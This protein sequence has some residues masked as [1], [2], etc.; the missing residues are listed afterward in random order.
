MTRRSVVLPEPDGP[1]SAS[2]SPASIVRSTPSS[3]GACPPKP[4]RMPETSTA[5]APSASMARA[6]PGD[7]VAVPPFEVGLDGQSDERQERE[8]GGDGESGG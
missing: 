3:A 2:S 1:S 5:R 7:R 6:A 8:E 4:L